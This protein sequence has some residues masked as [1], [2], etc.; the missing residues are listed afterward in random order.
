ME[1]RNIRLGHA[2]NSSSAHSVILSGGTRKVEQMSGPGTNPEFGWERFHLSEA[3]EKACYLAAAVYHSLGAAGLP[4]WQER[5]VMR[6]LFSGTPI[7]G[8]ID[9]SFDDHW[10][11]IYID[12]QSAFRLPNPTSKHFPA[13]VAEALE[14]FCDSRVSVDGGN[15]NDETGHGDSP[16]DEHETVRIRHDG[17]AYVVFNYATGAKVRM[18]PPGVSYDKASRPELV[19]IKITDA[20]PYGCA[21]C[22]QGSTRDG[23]EADWTT[24]RETIEALG[25]TGLGVFE[26]AIGGGEPTGSKHFNSVIDLAI[27]NMIVP[28]ITTFAVDWLLEERKVEAA[29]RCGG[30]GV[31]VHSA[32]DLSKWH[33]ING[34]VTGPSVV[35]QHV[36]GTRPADETA[37]IISTCLENG[38]HLLL[39]GYKSVGF[40]EQFKPHD[41][42]EVSTDKKLPSYRLKRPNGRLSVDTAMVEKHPEFLKHVGAH[43]L[44]VTKKE[45]A[46]SMYVDAVEQTCG[47]SSYCSPD[48]ML[49]TVASSVA[50]EQAFAAFQ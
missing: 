10:P 27:E 46:Y 24:L 32:D 35:A 38:I 40:G 22:Y 5:A 42:A 15:D 23:K 18:V 25:I 41:M 8:T 45:G 9:A 50:L 4:Q 26:I 29:N 39:L 12:H 19:D 3:S 1:I 14:F 11:G 47:P 30:I 31:S 49:P 13:V 6:E 17:D 20:C 33:K 48:Q 37:S 16:F 21:F 2:T 43:D 28:N 34:A 44:F 7:A 36:Y